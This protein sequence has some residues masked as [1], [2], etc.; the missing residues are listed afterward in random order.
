MPQ[1]W[2]IDDE[3]NFIT[4]FPDA[5]GGDSEAQMRAVAAYLMRYTR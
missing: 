2:P 3:G 1:F 4:P 5:L